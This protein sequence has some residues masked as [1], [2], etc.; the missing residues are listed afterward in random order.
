MTTLEDVNKTS[1]KTCQLLGANWCGYTKKQEAALDDGMKSKL[2]E[3]G[4]NVEVTD[5]ADEATTCPRLQGYPTWKNDQ[6]EMMA[7]Y[8]DDVNKLAEFCGKT[9]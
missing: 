9:A 2:K 3:R 8:T 7:G 6:G 5:C 4:I 1:E